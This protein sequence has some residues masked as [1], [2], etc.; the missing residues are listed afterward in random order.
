MR[1]SYSIIGRNIRNARRQ[2]RLTQEA[3]S[4]HLGI[5]LLHMGRLERGERPCSLNMLV[6]IAEALSISPNLLLKNSL[7]DGSIRFETGEGGMQPGIEIAGMAD[8]YGAVVLSVL[9]DLCRSITQYENGQIENAQIENRRP[10]EE[11]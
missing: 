4:E 10:S 5:S 1:I 7:I 3:L 2:A 9:N 6:R 11:E 8:G